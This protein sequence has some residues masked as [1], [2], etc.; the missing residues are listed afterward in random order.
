M[1]D[2]NPY[3]APQAAIVETPDVRELR[4]AGRGERLGAA[5]I[6]GLIIM[7]ILLPAMYMSGYFAGV[8][9][10]V[11]PSLAMR[12]MWGLIGFVLFVVVQGY[13]LSEHGQTWG[14]KLLKMKIVDLAGNKPDLL[15]LLGLRYLPTQ[16]IGLVPYVGGLY[17]LIDVLFIFGGDKRC[18]H[19]YIA[20]TRV[21]VAE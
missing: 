20:G 12:A 2:N 17:G 21:V 11:K 14:K 3:S 8:M 10:G 1:S 15:R 5:I 4:L 16:L 19:D 7:A 18:I 9:Q 13:P 6:D